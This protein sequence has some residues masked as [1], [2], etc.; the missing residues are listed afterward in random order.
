MKNLP[1]ILLFVFN[2]ISL[3]I[4]T[5]SITVNGLVTDINGEPLIGV[6]VQ[7]N[8]SSFGNLTNTYGFYS[9]TIQKETSSLQYSLIGFEKQVM[10]INPQ[11]DT[12]INIRLVPQ[13]LN[14]I[15]ITEKRSKTIDKVSTFELP[16]EQIKK[17]PSLAGEP[18]IFKVLA[19][20]PVA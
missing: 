10:T 12:I 17:I 11:N 18:D 4:Y 5:Q 8:G 20:Y 7:L 6:A 2:I 1:I 15:T 19:P 14:E 13:T 16:I 3:N 9:L